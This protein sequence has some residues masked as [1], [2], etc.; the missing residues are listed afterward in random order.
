MREDTVVPDKKFFI[1][2]VEYLRKNTGTRSI[3]AKAWN[4][5]LPVW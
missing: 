2:S 5:T 4:F 3:R 1:E